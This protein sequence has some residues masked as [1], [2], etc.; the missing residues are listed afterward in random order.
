MDSLCAQPLFSAVVHDD[1]GQVKACLKPFSVLFHLKLIVIAI[2]L[3]DRKLVLLTMVH[4]SIYWMIL[5]VLLEDIELFYEHELHIVSF[6]H[7]IF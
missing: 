7:C 4:K 6:L 1:L 5:D 3:G 2:K